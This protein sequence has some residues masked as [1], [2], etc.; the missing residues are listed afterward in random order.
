MRGRHRGCK[1]VCGLLREEFVMKEVKVWPHLTIVALVCAV[2]GGA[3]A[4]LLSKHK[5]TTEAQALT[6]P[7]RIERVDGTVGLARA[8]DDGA[9]GAQWIEVTPNTPLSV[10][11]RIYV[12]DNSRAALAFTGR[13]FARLDPGSALD[14]LTLSDR[15]TQLAL[16]DGSA[17]FDV[18]ALAPG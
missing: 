1:Y 3:A 10:G 4:M 15:R 13:N 18:G 11:D 16:R 2:L 5:L 7:A 8:L 9:A 17:I 14:V 6:V 12:R